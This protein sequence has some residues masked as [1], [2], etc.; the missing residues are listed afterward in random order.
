MDIDF[1]PLSPVI[2]LVP[3]PSNSSRLSAD[4]KTSDCENHSDTDILPVLRLT[5]EKC[6]VDDGYDV[7][8]T[9]GDVIAEL[10]GEVG[11]GEREPGSGLGREQQ[12]V[13]VRPP[14]QQRNVVGNNKMVSFSLQAVMLRNQM[15][16]FTSYMWRHSKAPN[17]PA[18]MPLPLPFNRKR[19][20][21]ALPI[22]VAGETIAAMTAFIPD[23]HTEK[24]R[25]RGK[26]KGPRQP[27]FVSQDILKSSRKLLQTTH[28]GTRRPPWQ[29]P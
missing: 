27:Y 14:A 24:K 18:A 7:D 3:E 16:M 21:D 10:D 9:G 2:F 19:T 11:L 6:A 12:N 8:D 23:R 28:A 25:T 5:Q 1:L 13:E 4:D 15:A 26:C 20:A 17:F 22:A 29:R